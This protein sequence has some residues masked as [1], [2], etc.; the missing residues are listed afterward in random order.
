MVELD[1]PAIL[2]QA[3]AA[4]CY[5]G[6]SILSDPCGECEGCLFRTN[7]PMLVTALEESQGV[8]ETVRKEAELRLGDCGDGTASMI[9]AILGESQ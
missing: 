8:L 4:M 1:L 5:G 6:Y 2:K 7:V 3:E 9:L